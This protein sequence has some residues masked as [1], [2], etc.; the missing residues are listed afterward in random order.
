MI[1]LPEWE[2]YEVFNLDHIKHKNGIILHGTIHSGYVRIATMI[3]GIHIRKFVHRFRRTLTENSLFF[4]GY[5][6]DKSLIINHKNGIKN[7]DKLTNV[8][9]V[10][11]SENT[12]HAFITD[13]ISI[14]L[15]KLNN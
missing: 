13:S 2:N 7:D 14:V 3:D 9:I 11:Y 12:Q 4:L 10:F 15:L 5:I 1:L 8:E 6:G